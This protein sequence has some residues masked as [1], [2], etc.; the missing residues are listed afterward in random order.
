MR[1]VDCLNFI[2]NEVREPC[3]IRNFSLEISHWNRPKRALSVK[4]CQSLEKIRQL[5]AKNFYFISKFLNFRSLLLHPSTII[6]Y[7]VYA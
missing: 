7:A 3:G 2:P 6:C 4:V 5:V 1:G